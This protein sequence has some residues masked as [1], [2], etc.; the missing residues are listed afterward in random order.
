MLNN[1]PEMISVADIIRAVD[2]PIQ[3]TSCEEGS[4]GCRKSTRCVTHHL[5]E[6]MGHHIYQYLESVNLGGLVAESR[7]AGFFQEMSLEPDVPRVGEG[8]K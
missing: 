8:G 5:W 1:N 2:E 6:R 7:N 4:E 3:A